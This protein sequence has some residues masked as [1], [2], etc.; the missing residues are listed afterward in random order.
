MKVT[1]AVLVTLP[2]GAGAARAGWFNEEAS[3]ADRLYGVPQGAGCPQA[4]QEAEPSARA[5]PCCSPDTA[6]A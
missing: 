5:S 2:F 4:E 6:R 1:V 3:E